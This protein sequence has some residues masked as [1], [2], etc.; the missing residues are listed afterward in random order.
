[1]V[2]KATYKWYDT[3]TYCTNLFESPDTESIADY[4]KKKGITDYDI[5]EVPD[6]E[7]ESS[8]RKGMPYI[9]LV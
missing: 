1:M 7:V 3:N 8:K 2:Y 9:T 5:Y 4:L 6:Y